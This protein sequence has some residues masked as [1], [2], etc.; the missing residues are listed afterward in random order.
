MAGI[1]IDPEM[2]DIYMESLNKLMAGSETDGG[3]A[4]LEVSGAG[5]TE[6]GL[7]RYNEE[8]NKLGDDLRELYET[9]RVNVDEEE[10]W[11][12]FD[13]VEDFFMEELEIGDYINDI[14]SYHLHMFDK[15][16]VTTKKFDAIVEKAGKVDANYAAQIEGYCSLLGE[17]GKKFEAVC[18]ML[19][20]EKLRLS[21]DKYREKLEGINTGYQNAK[22]THEQ[23]QSAYEAELYE[24]ETVWYKKM[25]DKAEDYLI[26]SAECIVLGNFTDEVTVLGVGVQIVLGI[27]DLDL[28]CDIRDIIADIKNLAE[29]DR[30]RWDLIGMLALDLI[31]LIPVIGALKYSD[32]VGTLF[33][34]AGKVSVVAE[35]ADGVGAVTRHADE[36]GAWLQGVKVFRYSDETAEAV[37]SGEKLL[38]ESGTIYESFADMM[39]PEDAKR[40]LDFLENGSR[41]G[42]TG[43]E[44]AGV[45]K[46]DALLVS[47]KVEYEDVWDLRN[48]GDLLES[49]KYSTQISPEMEK[50]I[51]EG[52]RKSPVKNEVIGGHSP[53]INNS[54]DLFAVEELSV[55]ADGTRNIKFVKDLQDGSI[56]KIKKST[57]FPDSWSDSKIIDTIKEVGD[58]PFISVRGRD[59]ATW[60]RKIVDGVEVDV[61]KLGNDVIS[62]YPTG[63]INAP[64]PSGF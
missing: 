20:P 16:D 64:K 56:S 63:K 25:L 29:T 22:D 8:V 2:L 6:D 41:E 27:F 15:H 19:Q 52:Q 60:H 12:V 53:Q 49:G 43:A 21:P 39:S 5:K 61:I 4:R 54:N 36:A 34:N 26:R 35:G 1:K 48:A 23:E 62:G 3:N 9:I 14:N 30:V 58:S 32:E 17:Y 45:E 44:L 57:V 46:A 59:G 11:K 24:I 55:N 42:L 10:Q 28:P 37:A 38:K 33:K 50:K 47:R 18:A 13:F 51:L 31:G 7:V 40:Y